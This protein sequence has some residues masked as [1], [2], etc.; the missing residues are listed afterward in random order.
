MAEKGYLVFSLDNRG[1]FGRGQEWEDAIYKD[2]G[3]YELQDQLAGVEYLRSLP[4][5]DGDRIGIWGWSYGGYMTLMALFKAPDAFK[6]GV[7]VAPLADWHL[8]DTIYTERYM[9]LPSENE[10]GYQNASPLNFVDDFEG[11]LLLMHGIADDN[12]HAQSSIQLAQKLIKAG[13]DFDLMLYP[14]KKHGISGEAEQ[15]FLYNKMMNFFDE[16][17][18]HASGSE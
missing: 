11:T 16:H 8:Y 9:K 10:E 7:A 17:L 1:S 15:V 3:N 6:A 12:V 5:V 18:L 14:Q 13:K 2:L 4:Y